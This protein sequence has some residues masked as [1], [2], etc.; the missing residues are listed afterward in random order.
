[1]PRSV[2]RRRKCHSP[3]A[4]S[5][6]KRKSSVQVRR[7]E[8]NESRECKL[9]AESAGNLFSRRKSS[10]ESAHSTSAE[11]HE[12]KLNTQGTQSVLH[13]KGC[14]L[15]PLDVT[16]CLKNA[17]D[18]EAM[19]IRILDKDTCTVLRP[20]VPNSQ[21]SDKVIVHPSLYHT[22]HSI[23]G[24]IR[25]NQNKSR[26]ASV[27]KQTVC[28]EK[29]HVR[30]LLHTKREKCGNLGSSR[31]SEYMPCESTRPAGTHASDRDNHNYCRLSGSN[32]GMHSFNQPSETSSCDSLDTTDLDT[33]SA[34]IL[35][36]P[37]ENG[38]LDTMKTSLQLASGHHGKQRED[39]SSSHE[40]EACTNDNDEDSED[41]T[42]G[43]DEEE[44]DD[45]DENE[46]EEEEEQNSDHSDE[47]SM[48]SSVSDDSY[49]KKYYK[50]ERNNKKVKSTIKIHTDRKQIVSHL[51]NMPL[52]S[53]CSPDRSSL[54]KQPVE[55]NIQ[56]KNKD[57]KSRR[58]NWQHAVS[59]QTLATSHPIDNYEAIKHSNMHVDWSATSDETHKVLCHNLFNNENVNMLFSIHQGEPPMNLNEPST[60]L[61]VSDDKWDNLPHNRDYFS[62]TQSI[63]TLTSTTTRK[64]PFVPMPEEEIARYKQIAL[65][66]LTERKQRALED[67]QNANDQPV[68]PHKVVEVQPR[69]LTKKK[70]SRPSRKHHKSARLKS[71]D[72]KSSDGYQNASCRSSQRAGFW[73][74]WRIK[75]Q[76]EKHRKRFHSTDANASKVC[77]PHSTQ[78][79]PTVR[80]PQKSPKQS[81]HKDRHSDIEHAAYFPSI[82][83][84]K[85]GSIKQ[86]P[87]PLGKTPR[88]SCQLSEKLKSKHDSTITNKKISNAS[89]KEQ[90]S[91]TKTHNSLFCNNHVAYR[92]SSASTPFTMRSTQSQYYLKPST[93]TLTGTKRASNMSGNPLK[94]GKP[95]AH[96]ENG[97]KMCQMGGKACVKRANR[98][99]NTEQANVCQTFAKEK[100]TNFKSE[101][102]S[103]EGKKKVT[104]QAG[105]TSATE[106]GSKSESFSKSTTSAVVPNKC[107]FS[108]DNALNTNQNLP[109]KL[110]LSSLADLESES[111]KR[112]QSTTAASEQEETS[113]EGV[114]NSSKS[115]AYL[116]LLQDILKSPTAKAAQAVGAFLQK[117]ETQEIANKASDITVDQIINSYQKLFDQLYN[118]SSKNTVNDK[119]RIN[120]DL[121]QMLGSSQQ[122]T[123]MK[124]LTDINL[125][126]TTVAGF[127]IDSDASQIPFKHAITENND[128]GYLGSSDEQKG[129]TNSFLKESNHRDMLP[130][131]A[132]GVCGNKPGWK[133]KEVTKST[134]PVAEQEVSQMSKYSMAQAAMRGKA[135]SSAGIYRS[136]VRP[137]GNH[138]SRPMWRSAA[139]DKRSVTEDRLTLKQNENKKSKSS[140]DSSETIK[141]TNKQSNHTQRKPA[142]EV[143]CSKTASAGILENNTNHES[144]TGRSKNTTIVGPSKLTSAS[145]VKK[146]SFSDSSC[147]GVKP[148]INTHLKTSLSCTRQPIAAAPSRMNVD[149]NPSYKCR[150]LQGLQDRVMSEG[151]GK[152]VQ[153]N[154]TKATN[155]AGLIKATDTSVQ[156]MATIQTNSANNS[157][158]TNKFLVHKQCTNSI[159]KHASLTSAG[160]SAR[161]MT[162]DNIKLTDEGQ[163]LIKDTDIAVRD[164]GANSENRDLLT[165]SLH[166]DGQY[167][168]VQE[169]SN[170]NGTVECSTK[171]NGKVRPYPAITI[172][173]PQACLNILAPNPSTSSQPSTA[174]ADETAREIE[175]F[176]NVDSLKPQLCLPVTA[177]SEVPNDKPIKPLDAN[178]EKKHDGKS[179]TDR[180]D[181]TALKLRNANT[182]SKPTRPALKSNSEQWTSG[183]EHCVRKLLRCSPNC[184][185]LES[186]KQVHFKSKS[187]FKYGLCASS[188]IVTHIPRQREQNTS[189]LMR[190]WKKAT[191]TT[192]TDVSSDEHT[193]DFPKA[194]DDQT[195]LTNSISPH[196]PCIIET[197]DISTMETKKCTTSTDTEVSSMLPRESPSK[198]HSQST[199]GHVHIPMKNINARITKPEEVCPPE[200]LG[201][202]KNKGTRAERKSTLSW[203]KQHLTK[204][205]E[206]KDKHFVTSSDLR[207]IFVTPLSPFHRV[208]DRHRSH[209][210][211]NRRP[212]AWQKRR[213][214]SADGFE[215]KNATSRLCTYGKKNMSPEYFPSSAAGKSLKSDTKL[216]ASASNCALTQDTACSRVT[217]SGA[218]A[219]GFLET[220]STMNSSK[221]QHCKDAIPNVYNPTHTPLKCVKSPRKNEGTAKKEPKTFEKRKTSPWKPTASEDESEPSDGSSLQA[222]RKHIVANTCRKI[223]RDSRNLIVSNLERHTREDSPQKATPVE[224]GCDQGHAEVQ[225]AVNQIINDT[226]DSINLGEV[227]ESI[228]IS[229]VAESE[230]KSQKPEVNLETRNTTDVIS[231]TCDTE[232]PD[233][234][235]IVAKLQDSSTKI[236]GQPTNNEPVDVCSVPL[237][238]VSLS[239]LE[240]SLPNTPASDV[241]YG[242]GIKC[243]DNIKDLSVSNK[244]GTQGNE[245]PPTHTQI[246]PQPA[247]T[248]VT[249]GLPH[250]DIF[251]EAAQHKQLLR[252]SVVVPGMDNRQENKQMKLDKQE[253]RNVRPE[254]RAITSD[255]ELVAGGFQQGGHESIV[256]TF[257]PEEKRDPEQNTKREFQ[258][259]INIQKCWDEEQNSENSDQ[260][261][262]GGEAFNITEQGSRKFSARNGNT[263]NVNDTKE[264]HC[265]SAGEQVNTKEH[266]NDDIG[267]NNPNERKKGRDIEDNQKDAFQNLGF[268]KEAMKDSEQESKDKEY[269]VRHKDHANNEITQV[270][271]NGDKGSGDMKQKNIPEHED[272]ADDQDFKVLDN[273]SRSAMKWNTERVKESVYIGQKNG[274]VRQGSQN[275]DKESAYILQQSKNTEQRVGDKQQD[276]VR[277]QEQKN[278]N[279]DEKSV[280][281]C[282]REIIQKRKDKEPKARDE[283][284]YNKSIN[285]EESKYSRVMENEDIDKWRRCRTTGRGKGWTRQKSRS[286]ERNK[287]PDVS[288]IRSLQQVSAERFQQCSNIDNRNTEIRPEDT[289]KRQ[290]KLQSRSVDFKNG[291]TREGSRETMG[292]H[293][294]AEHNRQVGQMSRNREF[295][296]GERNS[297]G[298]KTRKLAEV[299]KDTK[300]DKGEN[301]QLEEREDGH[302]VE[303]EAQHVKDKKR[304]KQRRMSPEDTK[305]RHQQRDICPENSYITHKLRNADL[306]GHDKVQE[307]KDASLGESDTGHTKIG[308][309]LEERD[310]IHEQAHP[311]LEQRNQIYKKKY[312][313][314]EERDKQHESRDKDLQGKDEN[315]TVIER[316]E[317]NKRRKEGNRNIHERYNR[318]RGGDTYLEGGNEMCEQRDPE[319][320]ERDKEYA[321]TDAQRQE[322]DSDNEKTDEECEE[323]DNKREMKLKGSRE[324]EECKNTACAIVAQM[325]SQEHSVQ[326][327][328][329]RTDNHERTDKVQR[330][331][332]AD[333]RKSVQDT[334]QHDGIAFEK[335]PKTRCQ[336]IRQST[337]ETQKVFGKYRRLNKE[338]R[339]FGKEIQL[340]AEETEHND[341][342]KKDMRHQSSDRK[343]KTVSTVRKSR[344]SVY[345]SYDWDMECSR[346]M[347]QDKR[348]V[349]K[350]RTQTVRSQEPKTNS[351]K[352]EITESQKEKT[353]EWCINRSKKQTRKTSQRC[354]HTEQH[355]KFVVQASL[356]DS[357]SESEDEV[358]FLATREGHEEL[359]ETREVC[360][361]KPKKCMGR[362]E[363]P[364]DQ[365]HKIACV[366]NTTQTDE[367]CLCTF[368][369]A[370][371]D[372]QTRDQH[373]EIEEILVLLANK[374]NEQDI[375][376]TEDVLQDNKIR[377]IKEQ[378]DFPETFVC[379]IDKHLSSPEVLRTIKVSPQCPQQ[380]HIPQMCTSKL[381][382]MEVDTQWKMTPVKPHE[383]ALEHDKGS[384]FDDPSQMHMTVPLLPMV[385]SSRELV[386]TV[387][388]A[389]SLTTVRG[390]QCPSPKKT[391]KSCEAVAIIS[392]QNLEKVSSYLYNGKHGITRSTQERIWNVDS[393]LLI[394]IGNEV[395]SISKHLPAIKQELPE[396]N[397]D[398]NALQTPLR[399]ATGH[400]GLSMP[401]DDSSDFVHM[402]LAETTDADTGEWSL[403]PMFKHN[404]DDCCRSATDMSTRVA[405]NFPSSVGGREHSEFVFNVNMCDTKEAQSKYQPRNRTNDDTM[406]ANTN[407]LQKNELNEGTLKALIQYQQRNKINDDPVKAHTQQRNG[408]SDGTTKGQTHHQQGQER[409]YDSVEA[410]TFH[411]Q[412]NA[413]KKVEFHIL[414]AGEPETS[415][416]SQQQQ[417]ITDVSCSHGEP[418]LVPKCE[419]H[420]NPVHLCVDTCG[421]VNTATEHVNVD[422]EGIVCEATHTA[423]AVLQAE[424]TD[425]ETWR[426]DCFISHSVSNR[427]TNC[428]NDGFRC[429]MSETPQESPRGSTDVIVDEPAHIA[430]HSMSSTRHSLTVN[431]AQPWSLPDTQQTNLAAS[432]KNFVNCEFKNIQQDL[433]LE[434]PYTSVNSFST[435]HEKVNTSEA[436]SSKCYYLDEKKPETENLSAESITMTKA[437][438]QGSCR[439]NAQLSEQFQ[440]HGSLFR[441]LPKTTETAYTEHS[442]LLHRM[443]PTYTEHSDLLHRI[444]PDNICASKNQEMVVLRATVQSNQVCPQACQLACTCAQSIGCVHCSKQ[445][446]CSCHHSVSKSHTTPGVCLH[447]SHRCCIVQGERTRHTSAHVS[448][449]DECP[450]SSKSDS[451]SAVTMNSGSKNLNE[452]EAQINAMESKPHEDVQ[453]LYCLC[454]A[455]EQGAFVAPSRNS[456]N[457]TNTETPNKAQEYAHVTGCHLH[458]DT[459]AMRTRERALKE[460]E[461][462]IKQS[463]DVSKLYQ[464]DSLIYPLSGKKKGMSQSINPNGKESSIDTAAVW[465]TD[466]HSSS[467]SVQTE[468]EE[469]SA[470]GYNFVDSCT[471]LGYDQV[472]AKQS[473]KIKLSHETST[474]TLL[475]QSDFDDS[476]ESNQSI[477]GDNKLRINLLRDSCIGTSDIETEDNVHVVDAGNSKHETVR[478]DESFSGVNQATSNIGC[479]KALCSPQSSMSS[480]TEG[481]TRRVLTRSPDVKGHHIQHK[482][483]ENLELFVKS[484][485]KRYVSAGE[486]RTS[487]P[488]K[489]SS[490]SPG[491]G[492][493]GIFLKDFVI[494]TTLPQHTSSCNLKPNFQ[495]LDTGLRD[496]QMNCSECTLTYSKPTTD[497]AQMFHNVNRQMSPVTDTKTFQKQMADTQISMNS[498][499]FSSSIPKSF[500]G[501]NKLHFLGCCEKSVTL[502]AI[503]QIHPDAGTYQEVTQ[504][505]LA[506]DHSM[507]HIPCWPK[508]QCFIS[509]PQNDDLRQKSM[510]S[511]RNPIVA[512]TNNE[513]SKATLAAGPDETYY[514]CVKVGESGGICSLVDQRQAVTNVARTDNAHSETTGPALFNKVSG[515][516]VAASTNTE[517]SQSASITRSCTNPFLQN[518]TNPFI[519]SAPILEVP[520]SQL[521]PPPLD[522]PGQ[523]VSPL[524]IKPN[525]F[526]DGKAKQLTFDACKSMEDGTGSRPRGKDSADCTTCFF[527]ENTHKLN[528]SAIEE[529]LPPLTAISEKISESLHQEQGFES[530]TPGKYCSRYLKRDGDLMLFSDASRDTDE[531]MQEDE[532][533]APNDK[534]MITLACP[535]GILP[536][537]ES[538]F[539]TMQNKHCVNVLKE[540]RDN[541]HQIVKKSNHK[542]RQLKVLNK[543]EV[544][545][546]RRTS[547]NSRINVELWKPT[548]SFHKKRV[549]LPGQSRLDAGGANSDE[550]ESGNNTSLESL[551]NSIS[552]NLTSRCLLLKKGNGVQNSSDSYAVY[553]S[554]AETL[555]DAVMDVSSSYPSLRS[556]LSE[557]HSD[558]INLG[559]IHSPSPS[560]C[561][562]QA[563]DQTA[564]LNIL[565]T[566]T[567]LTS[568]FMDIFNGLKKN[569]HKSTGRHT[570]KHK[571]PN[572][573]RYRHYKYMP[574]SK[575]AYPYRKARIGTKKSNYSRQHKIRSCF[576]EKYCHLLVPKSHSQLH[577][578][579]AFKLHKYAGKQKTTAMKKSFTVKSSNTATSTQSDEQASTSNTSEHSIFVH[580][581]KKH[582]CKINDD[583]S[584]S[585]HVNTE[586]MRL[587][588]CSSNSESTKLRAVSSH[589]NSSIINYI[590][591]NVSLATTS[592]KTVL[593]P[594]GEQSP[595]QT[596]SAQDQS[597]SLQGMQHAPNA[598]CH[599]NHHSYPEYMPYAFL[600]QYS[601]LYVGVHN[602]SYYVMPTMPFLSTVFTFV[603][604]GCETYPPEQHNTAPKL[605][606]VEDQVDD[607]GMKGGDVEADLSAGAKIQNSWK[608]TTPLQ[609]ATDKNVRRF[610]Q[611]SNSRCRATS[612]NIK[613]HQKESTHWTK[614]LSELSNDNLSDIKQ[615]RHEDFAHYVDV[616]PLIPNA[617]IHSKDRTKRDGNCE[618]FEQIMLAAEGFDNSWNE[619]RLHEPYCK[620]MTKPNK[621]HY[622]TA[623]SVKSTIHSEVSSSNL[624]HD[625]A[626]FSA[627]GLPSL[628]GQ[629]Y[630]K[631]D[632]SSPPKRRKC[633]HSSRTLCPVCASISKQTSQAWGHRNRDNH[634]MGLGKE[635]NRKPCMP[636]LPIPSMTFKSKLKTYGKETTPHFCHEHSCRT[637]KFL[638]NMKDG[639]ASNTY[640][641]IGQKECFGPMLR[642]ASP[643]CDSLTDCSEKRDCS[644]EMEVPA[645]AKEEK[646]YHYD[647]CEP[648]TYDELGSLCSEMQDTTSKL[649]Q[650]DADLVTCK[651]PACS[652]ESKSKALG[653]TLEVLLGQQLAASPNSISNAAT[654]TIHQVKR[655][656]SCSHYFGDTL[657]CSKKEVATSRR[658]TENKIC[659]LATKQ[660][661]QFPVEQHNLLSTGKNYQHPAGYLENSGYKKLTSP[662]WNIGLI[663]LR[664]APVSRSCFTQTEKGASGTDGH[665]PSIVEIRELMTRCIKSRHFKY[666]VQNIV[667]ERMR[668]TLPQKLFYNSDGNRSE[669]TRG[670]SSQKKNKKRQESLDDIGANGNTRARQH[671]VQTSL[672]SFICQETVNNQDEQII[673]AVKRMPARKSS[674]SGSTCVKQGLKD[675]QNEASSMRFQWPRRVA[676]FQTGRTTENSKSN[677]EYLINSRQLENALQEEISDRLRNSKKPLHLY[678]QKASNDNA[679]NGIMSQSLPTTQTA[680]EQDKAK[681]IKLCNSA[682]PSERM[683]K[684]HFCLSLLPRI[685]SEGTENLLG[686]DLLQE[687]GRVHIS[688]K[689]MKSPEPSTFKDTTDVSPYGK[690]AT[691]TVHVFENTNLHDGKATDLQLDAFVVDADF[692]NNT[693][694]ETSVLTENNKLHTA[695]L[696]ESAYCGRNTCE[697]D[698]SAARIRLTSVGC[699]CAATRDVSAQEM[700]DLSSSSSAKIDYGRLKNIMSAETKLLWKNLTRLENSY[701]RCKRCRK[702]YESILGSNKIS[703]E[704][705]TRTEKLDTA[706][707]LHS[708]D[709]NITRCSNQSTEMI[710]DCPKEQCASKNGDDIM[711][712]TERPIEQSQENMVTRDTDQNTHQVFNEVNTPTG[713]DTNHASRVEHTRALYLSSV[714]GSAAKCEDQFHMPKTVKKDGFKKPW[715]VKGKNTAKM[716]QIFERGNGF[717]QDSEQE[718]AS[719]ENLKKPECSRGE[720]EHEN[721]PLGQQTN[722]PLKDTV[723]KWAGSI[724]QMYNKKVNRSTACDDE[725]KLND[726]ESAM[727]SGDCINRTD[728]E[729]ENPGNTKCLKLSPVRCDVANQHASASTANITDAQHILAMN[730]PN[731]ETD[732]WI[733]KLVNILHEMQQTFPQ[734]TATSANSAFTQHQVDQTQEV[735]QMSDKNPKS[736][737]QCVDGKV[738]ELYEANIDVICNPTLKGQRKT[739][740]DT[741]PMDYSTGTL[742]QDHSGEASMPCFQ[743]QTNSKDTR[744][745]LDKKAFN[746]QDLEHYDQ[747]KVT[748]PYDSVGTEEMSKIV[749]QKITQE[750]IKADKIRKL[751]RSHQKH[752]A[753]SW[754]LKSTDLSPCLM[755]N[756]DTCP[757][758]AS[759]NKCMDENNQASGSLQPTEQL[760]CENI[761]ICDTVVPGRDKKQQ[762]CRNIFAQPYY[763]TKS[764]LD[765]LWR[766]SCSH[767]SELEKAS[768][769]YCAGKGI[770]N[771][772]FSV[773][774]VDAVRE[775]KSCLTLT[776][777]HSSAEWAKNKCSLHSGQLTASGTESQKQTFQHLYLEQDAKYIN[778]IRLGKSPGVTHIDQDMFVM[779]SGKHI[780]QDMFV[781]SSGKTCRLLDD[782]ATKI[783]REPKKFDWSVSPGREV[784]NCS[785]NITVQGTNR[786]NKCNV[787]FATRDITSKYG[788]RL[789]SE[790]RHPGCNFDARSVD[791]CTSIVSKQLKTDNLFLNSEM[792]HHV[793]LQDNEKIA[794][795]LSQELQW[796]HEYTNGILEESERYEQNTYSINRN[797][798][799]QIQRSDMFQSGCVESKQSSKGAASLHSCGTSSVLYGEGPGFGQ[800]CELTMATMND[801]KDTT[802][803]SNDDDFID[804]IDML[805]VT[806]SNT[807]ADSTE[808]YS[809]QKNTSNNENTDTLDTVPVFHRPEV[810]AKKAPKCSSPGICEYLENRSVN[811]SHF[812]WKRGRKCYS[813]WRNDALDTVTYNITAKRPCCKSKRH[814]SLSPPSVSLKEYISSESQTAN[815]DI[816]SCLR[817]SSSVQLESTNEQTIH[818][819]SFDIPIDIYTVPVYRHTSPQK[820]RKKRSNI[821]TRTVVISGPV[822]NMSIAVQRHKRSLD[823]GAVTNSATPAHISSLDMVEGSSPTDRTTTDQMA[824]S[825]YDRKSVP[826]WK[827]AMKRMLP[828]GK[829]TSHE[830]KIQ[831]HL[832]T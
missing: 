262:V 640:S 477:C 571:M 239:K 506:H 65:Q 522:K 269:G 735:I 678:F 501:V 433:H 114:N 252:D 226:K 321:N 70:R 525:P 120:D 351:R 309:L 347:Y 654:Q 324:Q 599:D 485:R 785:K 245:Y 622:D 458:K 815:K 789:L 717:F 356:Q 630:I 558:T 258:E 453:C 716:I 310:S 742:K 437:S 658:I 122:M 97:T 548:Y 48:E 446:L 684:N 492:Y 512:V 13:N 801:V 53:Q 667:D 56:C 619:K 41:E 39:D 811:R 240:I 287:S 410:D 724:F 304:Y 780:D 413:P 679:I 748:K 472:R 201:C 689:T 489:P 387:P 221:T 312:S 445:I 91:P 390:I 444:H 150:Q 821:P 497:K 779:S 428:P 503:S 57:L 118:L 832:V 672:P 495:V 281:H 149:G 15:L 206:V 547:R 546:R 449:R 211:A 51:E 447:D 550:L 202:T 464:D 253:I 589:T 582:R 612:D 247:H 59:K 72:A 666:Y 557:D 386:K 431:S 302:D 18:W 314:G 759:P 825:G 565:E 343:L 499:G 486:P 182:Q 178:K 131:A 55:S 488:Y 476:L 429:R 21:R 296:Y 610:Q 414:V 394:L 747:C 540:I 213:C 282:S 158:L 642:S 479:A 781:T 194:V 374:A 128:Q 263:Q 746:S 361:R 417:H 369:T 583:L 147:C 608:Q 732:E 231:P 601:Q 509:S 533:K 524:N 602:G 303:N 112:A 391:S 336:N 824:V 125:Q 675:S 696:P 119:L 763:A 315:H 300:Q 799:S 736:L 711:T 704:C 152:C 663:T 659:H 671:V 424:H 227:V 84:A 375:G 783:P 153:Q 682:T 383:Q 229:N 715:H 681:S 52:L 423:L 171:S 61:S 581:R 469:R 532:A 471:C 267:Q 168:Q 566:V 376:E 725:A 570:T 519:P 621:D 199:N 98:H 563:E 22:D 651:D 561:Q 255:R 222:V 737:L 279:S 529:F 184:M 757:E 650:G 107:K 32:T 814:K 108:V 29:V 54:E 45:D 71:K 203:S 793:T 124:T 363:M 181:S 243:D 58:L 586:Y 214:R 587:P 388:S 422:K 709:F 334:R 62:S 219:V 126:N 37:H 360:D 342:A 687:H 537:Q 19:E 751:D 46:M 134:L 457:D 140:H 330:R 771:T 577:N 395:N 505:T 11:Q 191:G 133:S 393:E 531:T 176:G 170:A 204:S 355:S 657:E 166:I 323:K 16:D 162:T 79:C 722:I 700:S 623:F 807:Q 228:E 686:V 535:L 286:V 831:T 99:C 552:D 626:R 364:H 633:D 494:Q 159:K 593:L 607:E 474:Q 78:V 743:F 297:L 285:H 366:T 196:R 116:D 636:N 765:R 576:Q 670:L 416:T 597:L 100:Q 94:D 230:S 652:Y 526:L 396:D 595:V 483:M 600:P 560:P 432:P 198:P 616:V 562:A 208:D 237:E 40:S 420:V 653:P 611:E 542:V 777:S 788:R 311:H 381:G 776:N 209:A 645:M 23:K 362:S 618:V 275:V 741:P 358:Y 283:G 63:S 86:K 515:K 665:R 8:R 551:N 733:Q 397:C 409:N 80:C 346:G 145:T 380:S 508:A 157:G 2:E 749:T 744:I 564:N 6:S 223:I 786:N 452:N 75:N 392:P 677:D 606:L 536:N 105:D 254:V 85:L 234:M 113:R 430:P 450:L 185:A 172:F 823:Q 482:A 790:S 465:K 271:I 320:E 274:D 399:S 745:S 250:K 427:E 723:S 60:S 470:G 706:C 67:N 473:L 435:G 220:K 370:K 685:N 475:K 66:I 604:D 264:Q 327:D 137:F 556:C 828:F 151:K 154:V 305:E 189:A 117:P 714:Q 349:V 543:Q 352:L 136:Q 14:K 527:K 802:L 167:H 728:K 822:R 530:N 188:S 676:V 631:D 796:K 569:I 73:A 782:Y 487:P 580:R 726:L 500:L 225:N 316:K 187:A 288:Q 694:L 555:Y 24:S 539:S 290:V 816:S 454:E 155:H 647:D 268:I 513:I 207:A 549:F 496:K 143:R 806:G 411:H 463:L 731:S 69:Q 507:L 440:H 215:V 805:V 379:V 33:A 403:L 712:N 721:T 5:C 249:S 498:V 295:T 451:I 770:S 510:E 493:Q 179:I 401:A 49:Y 718:N 337:Y 291:D 518:T 442:N 236:A 661:C 819:Q 620:Y 161:T 438:L 367:T 142:L 106:V 573:Q 175:V 400:W 146:I 441:D 270:S 415:V 340:K 353:D 17:N 520:R 766:C 277:E 325:D 673:A 705:E 772:T 478:L 284:E 468:T 217:H 278:I 461:N 76:I 266:K 683:Q 538:S 504:N 798:S 104:T 25:S 588:V 365:L 195:S 164:A 382:G 674:S 190:M 160:A 443:H 784:Y 232:G 826:T 87:Q 637:C 669:K 426:R 138:D 109:E 752:T 307:E 775:V 210:E 727:K 318:P 521:E 333:K 634:Q 528:L 614:S 242:K 96:Y 693:K 750:S 256:D 523:P 692:T 246:I 635:C 591:S 377:I 554:S 34:H 260:K 699:A 800:S 233:Y 183:D 791:S 385:E 739:P 768:S 419:P 655:C 103:T 690:M 646:Q 27:L 615:L 617:D 38:S 710:D 186:Q 695:W 3:R 730:A 680:D 111:Q 436:N 817:S 792:V 579:N 1:M 664:S 123:E 649:F 212:L 818:L 35:H 412:M 20:G 169:H 668:S 261:K 613:L 28:V 384:L 803:I 12:S 534:G 177:Y 332:Y 30:N 713:P 132:E 418:G 77:R 797:L 605:V 517:T 761:H 235:L 378:P 584:I 95:C 83:I 813:F 719:N 697:T 756:T 462:A 804:D 572:L 372:V 810:A 81:A 313:K 516:A 345:E 455:K 121:T 585:P 578:Q 638:S 691:E 389:E 755:S 101:P 344:S 425:T 200:V 514:M 93:N 408:T 603:G 708:E 248:G 276:N 180:K 292:K 241:E 135:K 257:L 328:C 272:N 701:D 688:E 609:S 754:L 148:K 317:I 753:L 702:Q 738:E 102:T 31:S 398:I 480:K 720:Q 627:S 481:T 729:Q 764:N 348:G 130:T 50:E 466:Q 484:T 795:D 769:I 306:C 193:D 82:M 350:Y 36:P 648:D 251:N 459:V 644:L 280:E 326:E 830:K 165:E 406:E 115:R 402:P 322:T 359:V 92:K 758:L 568:K 64:A 26:E 373:T 294:N 405:G 141:T 224:N 88:L 456:C 545:K 662:I 238:N 448:F 643:L 89:F 511:T 703:G 502:P 144:R 74:S 553:N 319:H 43:S 371:K 216:R 139:P 7:H 827:H 773:I 820:K 574:I 331:G 794:T 335:S 629:Y 289:K 173:A 354:E 4:L 357:K 598:Q 628:H 218:K 44:S 632:L 9:R 301:I 809:E 760:C 341:H 740:V 594:A 421:I 808:T 90:K 734:I 205:K 47:E 567:T 192:A 434:M 244:R 339:E 299:N 559:R 259:N 592:D 778:G 10:R 490:Q 829:R 491:S 575:N 774:T 541:A 625:L 439:G 641:Y 544:R 293:T 404:A 656:T 460:Q 308:M 639:G 42:Y 129:D 163:P 762:F 707:E 68:A 624:E 110:S 368:S 298:G 787:C 467:K 174:A 329:E 660:T 812:P 156:S 265:E 338:S 767:N 407:H 127:K 197:A 273:E 698:E 590:P 596:E